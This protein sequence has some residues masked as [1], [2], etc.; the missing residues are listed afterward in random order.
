MTS[1]T[2]END[3]RPD[4]SAVQ[5]LPQ[6][7]HYRWEDFVRITKKIIDESIFRQRAHANPHSDHD[8]NYPVCPAKSVHFADSSFSSL[9]ILQNG[10][11]RVVR[12]L[13]EWQKGGIRGRGLRLWRTAHQPVSSLSRV[14]HARHGNPYE[15]RKKAKKKPATK[16]KLTESMGDVF[17]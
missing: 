5:G 6:K 3:V 13:C 7:R 14:T 11:D 12:R 10:L 2:S 4:L 15:G 9:A 17:A 16:L 1:E 8:I